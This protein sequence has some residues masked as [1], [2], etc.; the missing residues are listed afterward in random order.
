MHLICNRNKLTVPKE[1]ACNPSLM[2]EVLPVAANKAVVSNGNAL[3]SPTFG[4]VRQCGGL[5]IVS[6]FVIK[7]CSLLKPVSNRKYLHRIL[8]R[9]VPV[10]LI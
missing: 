1:F 8:V 2:A 7:K 9:S 6:K 10:S 3:C 5:P 4:W